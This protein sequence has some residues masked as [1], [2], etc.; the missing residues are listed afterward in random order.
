MYL[1]VNDDESA[2]SLLC[3][4]N[5]V[6]NV[7]KCCFVVRLMRLLTREKELYRITYFQ[8]YNILITDGLT[9]KIYIFSCVQSKKMV[10]L[11]YLMN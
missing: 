9:A 2:K 6:E 11:F 7:F 5:S 8:R 3:A 4:L 10:H 1:T